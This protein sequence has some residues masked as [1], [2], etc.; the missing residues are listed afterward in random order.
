MKFLKLFF[1]RN[2]VNNKLTYL[3]NT[4]SLNLHQKHGMRTT[5]I[6]ERIS[7]MGKTWRDV[8]MVERKS[9]VVGID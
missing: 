8:M 9:Q 6:T 3:N 4:G 1:R 2:L 5:R 7:K